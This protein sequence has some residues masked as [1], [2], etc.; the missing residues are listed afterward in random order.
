MNARL[1]NIFAILF[2]IVSLFMWAQSESEPYAYHVYYWAHGTNDEIEKLRSDISLYNNEEV[3]FHELDNL[4]GKTEDFY[5]KHHFHPYEAFSFDSLRLDGYLVHGVVHRDGNKIFVFL[6][7]YKPPTGK[8]SYF[9]D[10]DNMMESF[11]VSRLFEKNILNKS[12]TWET[13]R[14]RVFRSS[15]SSYFFKWQF[16]FY[17]WLFLIG[18]F[19]RKIESLPK[20]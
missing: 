14:W 8:G 19:L 4:M 11:K 9:G 12:V 6:F 18:W 16:V 10:R 20:T 1:Y 5:S 17:V 7:S 13:S 2:C 15:Y 3:S